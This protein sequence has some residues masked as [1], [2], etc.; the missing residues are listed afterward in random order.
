MFLLIFIFIPHFLLAVFSLPS[1]VISFRLTSYL[2]SSPFLFLSG[3]LSFFSRK[4]TLLQISV[5]KLNSFLQ[6]VAVNG[7]WAVFESFASF[8][9]FWLDREVFY[10]VTSESNIL[11][12]AFSLCISMSW[13]DRM[14]V[15]LRANCTSLP[16]AINLWFEMF[17]CLSLFEI[18]LCL[19][20]LFLTICC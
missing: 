5:R 17:V 3:C 9:T 6:N 2:T 13:A 16:R 7:F 19:F 18:F 20:C 8:N 11:S 10:Y 15:L 1:S 4:N 12:H 14:T